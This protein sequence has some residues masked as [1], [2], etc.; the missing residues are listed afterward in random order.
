MAQRRFSKA[1]Q[2][3]TEAKPGT[4]ERIDQTIERIYRHLNTLD[5]EL[6]AALAIVVPPS[7]AE[8]LVGASDPGLPQARVVTQSTTISW[9]LATPLIAKADVRTNSISNTLIRQGTALSVIGN[10]TNALANVADI[11]AASA[12]TVLKRNAANALEFAKVV[13]A[14]TSGTFPPSGHNLLSSAHQDTLADGAV[15]GDLIRAAPASAAALASEPWLD[16]LPYED[17][18]STLGGGDVTYWVDGLP[19]DSIDNTILWQRVPAGSDG[20]YLRMVSGLPAWD[21]D[22]NLGYW[23]AYTPVW[24][25]QTTDPSL[26][27]GTLEGRYMRMGKTIFFRI[28]LT[29][30]ATTTLGSN[31][32]KFTLPFTAK[33]RYFV[34]TCIVIDTSG[35]I[36]AG[37]TIPLNT[38]QVAVGNLAGS[39]GI[40]AAGAWQSTSPI[41]VPNAGDAYTVYGFYEE[42]A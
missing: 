18:P 34:A 20:S 23:I 29:I 24:T 15:Y 38:T 27:D 36:Y 42:E 40:P 5:A 16:G 14:D 41:A 25:A 10:A 17:L 26:G 22:P 39:G 31:F 6:Q 9:D 12:S 30:G 1:Y 7:D 2:I 13:E 8:F 35:T 11:V 33:D 37:Y 28:V 3:G 21:A 19:Y 32:W 4:F